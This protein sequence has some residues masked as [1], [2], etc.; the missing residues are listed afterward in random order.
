MGGAGQCFQEEG[1]APVLLAASFV[2]AAAYR[3]RRRAKATFRARVA[4]LQ[5]TG[6][7]RNR[8][9]V[10]ELVLADAAE[11]QRPA[12]GLHSTAA[13]D[14]AH[15]ARELVRVAVIA[16]RAAG[17]TGADVG[18]PYELTADA[19]RA[20]WGHLYLTWPPEQRPT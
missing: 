13:A 20:R 4:L 17:A 14:A 6:E 5:I 1:A 11:Q 18:R 16:D 3:G 2:Q 9:E 7:I 12:P 15:L 10:L 19:A 8:C